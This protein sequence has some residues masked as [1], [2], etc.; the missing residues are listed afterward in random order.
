MQ[1]EFWLRSPGEHQ[2]LLIVGMDCPPRVGELVG[3]TGEDGEVREVHSVTYSI[4]AEK[5]IARVLLRI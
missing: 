4:T 2:R 3:L 5:Q 1:V